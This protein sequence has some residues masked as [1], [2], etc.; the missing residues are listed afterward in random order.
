MN[1]SIAWAAEVEQT[2]RNLS[3]LIQAETVNP[4]GNELPAI[5]LVKEYS[6]KSRSAR[7]D[8][9]HRRIGAQSS[10]PGGAPARRWLTASAAA[11]RARGRGAGG[12]RALES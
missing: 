10:E 12:E 8:V 7:R 6:G 5:L 9:H 3:R 2:V 4:P 11:Q 1:T